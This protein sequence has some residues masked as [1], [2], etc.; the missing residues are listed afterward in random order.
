M[1]GGPE[2]EETREGRGEEIEGAEESGGEERPGGGGGAGTGPPR[3][4]RKPVASWSE[5][6]ALEGRVER[7][8]VVVLRTRGCAWAKCSMCGYH[9][10]A[11]PATA[12][13]I[14]AQLGVWLGGVGGER[15][16]KIYTSG[17]FF[18]EREIPPDARGAILAAVGRRFERVVVET[19]P[20]FL[21]EGALAAALAACP[22]LEVALGLESVSPRVLEHSI[23]KGF[24]LSDFER[25]AA[26]VRRMGGR[27]RTYILLKPPFLTEREALED[28]V[29]SALRAA[30]LSHCISLNPV[31]V[32]RGT[33]VEALWKRGLY[34]PPWLWTVAECLVRSAR[35]LRARG[36]GPQLVCAPSG[37]GRPRGAH[38]CGACDRTVIRALSSLT[39]TQ[40]E[41]GLEEALARG[42]SCAGEWRDAIEVGEFTFINYDALLRRA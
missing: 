39:L 20:G 42:C 31:N 36:P 11:V 37:A 32:Q 2:G 40:S 25:A 23:G 12:E 41:A 3:D 1:V 18:D 38:N 6:E 33:P 22:Q 8:A 21:S 9:R 10:E 7:A 34:R 26:L 24:A 30:P 13:D 4:P 19:R 28:A 35:E 29:S 15:V 5:P 14:V 17:S 27:V 16:A